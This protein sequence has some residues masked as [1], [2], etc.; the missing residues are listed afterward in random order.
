MR[1][2]YLHFEQKA[3]LDKLREET[4]KYPEW[5][6]WDAENSTEAE[7]GGTS[8]RPMSSTTGTP[9]PPARSGFKLKLNGRSAGAAASGGQS[10]RTGTESQQVSG[11]EGDD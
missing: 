9:A 3:C 6:D 11:D 7:G 1:E 10:S 2:I 5:A 8:T 4:A